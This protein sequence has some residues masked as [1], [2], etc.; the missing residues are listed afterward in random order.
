MKGVR[1]VLGLLCIAAFVAACGGTAG[2]TPVGR[3]TPLPT[4]T[5]SALAT[6]AASHP[7]DKTVSLNLFMYDPGSP[8]ASLQTTTLLSQVNTDCGL[9]WID[10]DVTSVPGADVMTQAPVPRQAYLSAEIPVDQGTAEATAF[11]RWEVLTAWAQTNNLPD[12]LQT[13]DGSFSG[14]DGVL[15]AMRAGGYVNGVPACQYPTSIR[16][17]TADPRSISYLQTHGWSAATSTAIV[18]T[19]PACEGTKIGFPAG[20]QLVAPASKPYSQVITG[21]SEDAGE[22]GTLWQVTGY[23]NCGPPELAALCG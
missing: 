5:P 13:L 19:F 23:A 11:M 20:P 15:A 16:V 22:F 14:Q 6:A 21:T 2:N 4:P 3:G 8:C 12:V 1:P 17:V 18:A 10:N 7:T 9:L